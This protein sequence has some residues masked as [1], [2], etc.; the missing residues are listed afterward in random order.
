MTPNRRRK[1]SYWQIVGRQFGKNRLAVLGL[2][3]VLLLFVVAMAAPF[4]AGERPIYMTLDGKA[5]WLPNLIKYKDLLD[6][7]F[8][9]WEPAD[10]GRVVRPP[11]PYSPLSQEL[12]AR[13]AGP[14]AKHWLAPTTGAGTF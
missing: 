12:R 13:L 7:D 6:I 4:L 2:A 9:T 1:Q 3:L 14:T 11:I 10:G 5:Y 8:R